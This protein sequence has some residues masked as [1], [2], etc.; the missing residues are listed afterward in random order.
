MEKKFMDFSG[1]KISTVKKEVREVLMEEFAQFLAEKYTKSG[2]V[3]S[4]ELAVV[5]GHFTDSDGFD[6]EVTAV[7]KITAKPFYDS[8]GAKGRETT[9][10][11]IE[12]AIEEY[13]QEKNSKVAAKVV[14]R[15]KKG[16]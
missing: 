15:R 9:S 14:G 13:E 1:K 16:E 2:Q 6:N 10:Y 8:V 11:I 7:V 12:D 3:A 5:L 4:N